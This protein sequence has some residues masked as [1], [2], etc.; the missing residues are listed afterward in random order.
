MSNTAVHQG[1]SVHPNWMKSDQCGLG[2]LN[3]KLQ[4]EVLTVSFWNSVGASALKL[5]QGTLVLLA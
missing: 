3:R 2:Q 4:A 5:Y 1:Y